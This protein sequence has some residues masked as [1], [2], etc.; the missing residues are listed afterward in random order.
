MGGLNA[1]TN[2][3][4]YQKLIHEIEKAIENPNEFLKFIYS[5]DD[6]EKIVKPI[7]LIEKNHLSYLEAFDYFS[8][9]NSQFH[10]GYIAN[11]EH[12]NSPYL[13]EEASNKE[14][15]LNLLKKAFLN[16]NAIQIKYKNGAG[17]DSNRTLSH[18][19]CNDND[20]KCYESYS[21]QAIFIHEI[22]RAHV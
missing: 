21:S 13:S 15:I 10:I 8:N 20:G 7:K 14:Q 22:G 17:V 3:E 5:N 2:S 1:Y 11:L 9:I 6:F 16:L 19:Q 18:I 12:Q 4:E